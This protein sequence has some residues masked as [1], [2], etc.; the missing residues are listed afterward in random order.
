MNKKE[1][2]E[3]ILSIGFIILMII[4]LIG[5]IYFLEYKPE[6]E[7]LSKECQY[8]K[9]REYVNNFCK[10]KGYDV[11]RSHCVNDC[12]D[13][14]ITCEDLHSEI[15]KSKTFNYN[16]YNIFESLEEKCIEYKEKNSFKY[17][18]SEGGEQ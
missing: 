11:G 7:R 8:Q 18:V 13:H 6:A 15:H 16:R 4:T 9:H 17:S 14:S 1:K 10:E 2:R 12:R 5:V 3:A